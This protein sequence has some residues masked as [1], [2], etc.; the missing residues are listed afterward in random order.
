MRQFSSVEE[1]FNIEWVKQFR[2]RTT[3]R[4]D[5]S[6]HQYSIEVRDGAISLIAEYDQGYE[7]SVIGHMY[8]AAHIVNTIP[9]WEPKFKGKPPQPPK[10]REMY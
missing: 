1:L 9:K 4:F 5:P 6:F 3:G 8:D 7:W 2:L 10:D